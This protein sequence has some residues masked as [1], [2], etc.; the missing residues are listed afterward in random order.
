MQD[1]HRQE[2]DTL[3][4]NRMWWQDRYRDVDALYRPAY[5]IMAPIPPPTFPSWLQRGITYREEF[6]SSPFL[7]LLVLTGCISY[8]M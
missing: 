3:F 4:E 7:I 5:N 1:P 6:V 8:K 2:I